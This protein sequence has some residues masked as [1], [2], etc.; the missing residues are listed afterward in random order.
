MAVLS[1]TSLVHTDTLLDTVDLR[2]SLPYGVTTAEINGTTFVYAAGFS[3]DAIQVMTL[4]DAGKLT[5][6]GV[7]EDLPGTTLNGAISAES[8]S[9]GATQFLAVSGYSDD[10]V[11]VYTL[12]DTGPYVAFA[13]A[14]FQSENA[15]DYELDFALGL[16]FLSLSGGDFLYVLG[17]S[18]ISVFS[19]GAAG[20]LTNVQNVDDTG[21][22]ELTNG[23]GLQEFTLGFTQ[24]IL[25][26]GEGD[27]GVSVFS[28]DTST[29]ALT[30][31]ASLDGNPTGI[32]GSPEFADV[33]VIDGTAYFYVPEFHSKAITVLAFDGSTITEHQRLV[34]DT[35]LDGAWH[36]ELVEMG[37]QL[38]L[39]LTV[40]QPDAVQF[41]EINTAPLSGAVGELT[42]LQTL[43][44]NAG[45]G[46]L[47]FAAG[48][49]HVT[50]SGTTYLLAGAG[51]TDDALN[52]YEVG[53]G[54]DL[55]TGT[56]SSDEISGASGDDTLEGR[57]G[58]DTIDG[59]NGDD[60][61]FGGSGNDDMSGDAGSDELRGGSGND[62]IRG[63]DGSDRGWGSS[64]ADTLSGND[65][66]DTLRGGDEDDRLFG[67]NDG[68]VLAGN[69]GDDYLR[70]NNEND[71]VFGGAGDDDLGGDAGD[72]TV[73]GGLGDD[74]IRGGDGED[75]LTGGRGADTLAGNDGDDVL[76]GGADADRLIGGTGS[77]TLTGE[78]GADTFVFAAELDSP[79]GSGRDVITDFEA[80]TDV[81][82]LS[83]FS[84]TLSFVAS[85]TGTAGEVRYND[86][87]GRLYVDIDGDSASDFSV[88]VGAGAGLSESDLIL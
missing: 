43:Q 66:A 5:A 44:D 47:D 1:G 38:M 19:V 52:V 58:A 22:L 36:S 74:L 70:G 51:G 61:L 75:V 64:G 32:L 31:V 29:G 21:T 42:H 10:G 40:R 71:Q 59:G 63:G 77:D 35:E 27:D 25:A 60:D 84:G 62:L 81:I 11:T 78:S 88:D 67:G 15:A 34:S 18:G 41:F 79:H 56:T 83:G 45:E 26:T 12:S 85:Y 20:G 9:I 33:A 17:S 2:L 65:G 6:V 57:S 30:E 28:V 53:G 23:R 55:V 14:V 72:D 86:A 3:E 46:E 39:A 48:L 76:L 69:L 82:D 8:F 80:G 13:D 37:D 24:Y 68:D 16:E 50:I 87:V 7:I 73:D 49:H 54:D 4:S